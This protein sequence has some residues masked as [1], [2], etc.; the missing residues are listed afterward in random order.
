MKD[1]NLDDKLNDRLNKILLELK[2][3]MLEIDEME[4]E[5]SGIIGD[6]KIKQTLNCKF[7]ILE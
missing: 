1:I 4:I 5:V 3:I 6:T 2:E 7:E